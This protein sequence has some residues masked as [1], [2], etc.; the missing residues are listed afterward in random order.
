METWAVLLLTAL[1]CGAQ[2]AQQVVPEV[3]TDSHGNVAD[4]SSQLT[5]VSIPAGEEYDIDPGE[6][7][8][9]GLQPLF[10]AMQGF[11]SVC[12]GQI[13]YGKEISLYSY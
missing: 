13:P 10:N 3:I 4:S 11:V 5:F 12:F 2:G 9:Q 1:V 8:Y 7:S 6:Y